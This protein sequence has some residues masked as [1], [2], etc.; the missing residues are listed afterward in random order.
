MVEAII[1]SGGLFSVETD[2][3]TLGRD[4]ICGIDRGARL[5]V[6]HH[7]VGVAGQLVRGQGDVFRTALGAQAARRQAGARSLVDGQASAHIRQTK[8]RAPIPAIGRPI[9][10]KERVVL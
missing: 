3:D 8:G 2:A 7:I 10:R 4:H 1:V 5:G 6:C 9:E